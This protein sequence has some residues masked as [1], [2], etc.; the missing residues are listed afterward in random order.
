MS[1]EY[2]GTGAGDVTISAEC[3]SLTETYSIEDC[4]YY[5][6]N[7]VSQTTTQGSTI[8]DSNLSQTLPNKCEISYDFYSDNSNTSGEHRF[9]LLP[10]SQYSSGTTQPSYALY[11]DQK[12]GNKGNIGKRDNG[13]SVGILTGFTLQVDEYHTLKYVKD[14]TSVSTYIDGTLMDTSTYS[15]IDNYTDYTV[16]MIRWSSSGTSKVKNVKFKPL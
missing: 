11:L 4:N 15:W 9:F 1:Y 7:E 2:T 6:T 8:Y 14:G 16:S 10:K 13:S 5:N 3:E 12:G